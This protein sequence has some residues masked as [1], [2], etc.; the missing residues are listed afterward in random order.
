MTLVSLCLLW[1]L[2]T[3]VGL[4]C[5]CLLTLGLS[6]KGL[7]GKLLPSPFFSLLSLLPA[8]VCLFDFFEVVP[9]L[10]IPT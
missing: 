5:F 2:L 10:H 8:A 1:A 3:V 7:Q 9:L 4:L 6:S